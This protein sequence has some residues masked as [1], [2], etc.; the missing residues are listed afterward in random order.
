MIYALWMRRYAPFD[1]FGLGFQ[2]DKRSGA[3]TAVDAT[4]R[5]I[6][7]VCFG[8]GFVSTSSSWSSGSSF[9]GLGKTIRGNLGYPHGKV[10]SSVSVKTKS[11]S[12]VRFTFQTAGA[13]PMIPFGLAPDIDSFLDL[14]V[15]FESTALVLTGTLSGDSFPNA[16]VFIWDDR[17]NSSLMLDFK[18]GGGRNTGPFTRL[19]GEGVNN[20][21]QDF[22]VR[23]PVGPVGELLT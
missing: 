5:T 3:T 22:S 17:G 23:L 13:N 2:G 21:V 6:G 12:L 4:A 18:T 14:T 1:E 9:T 15:S 8:P 7:I 11:S 16:E 10:T 20:S 19:F